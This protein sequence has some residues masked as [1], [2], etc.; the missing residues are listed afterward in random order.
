MNQKI[1]EFFSGLV[2]NSNLYLFNKFLLEN[3]EKYN[4]IKNKFYSEI[5]N[6]FSASYNNSDQ[7]WVDIEGRPFLNKVP[8]VKIKGLTHEIWTLIK[9]NPF[10][11]IQ[12]DE[13]RLDQEMVD[14]ALEQEPILV[15]FIPNQFI[16]HKNAFKAVEYEPLFLEYIPES[17]KTY[18][19]VNQALSSNIRAIKFTPDSLITEAIIHE[20]ES[21]D[22]F[23]LDFI[24]YHIW[25]DKIWL[26]QSGI[27]YTK[28][29]KACMDLSII[30]NDGSIFELYM[31]GIRDVERLWGIF[32]ACDPNTYQSQLFIELV[33]RELLKYPKSINFF[34]MDF[35]SIQNYK[36]AI[37]VGAIN[38]IPL[39]LWEVLYSTVFDTQSKLIYTMPTRYKGLAIRHAKFWVE[40]WLKLDD[41]DKEKY[42][43][44]GFFITPEIIENDDMWL[45]L[46]ETRH[47]TKLIME[48]KVNDIEAMLTVNEENTSI[49]EMQRART[50]IEENVVTELFKKNAYWYFILPEN[51]KTLANS[52]KLLTNYPHLVNE[53]PTNIKTMDDFE[54][55]VRKTNR[56]AISHLREI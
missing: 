16:T 37:K 6:S 22:E 1:V 41:G 23:I 46:Y 10:T 38:Y 54:Q 11:I 29:F 12:V 18:K 43:L 30:N 20:L 13:S 49:V 3:S 32:G 47:L 40:S 53:L 17:L 33:D 27:D 25:N 2:E 51:E 34:D 9:R 48:N 4:L 19:I 39:H 15:C 36:T 55:E 24:P 26:K 42:P 44:Q 31:N 56:E 14:F 5:N 28:T 21:C 8:D 35:L 50:N 7:H 45:K 52:L